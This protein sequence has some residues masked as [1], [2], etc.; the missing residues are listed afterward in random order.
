MR[1]KPAA[2]GRNFS[3]KTE[4]RR[5]CATCR[6]LTRQ[7]ARVA[8]PRR[9]RGRKTFPP[10]ASSRRQFIKHL[11]GGAAIAAAGSAVGRA[12]ESSASYALTQRTPGAPGASHYG[13]LGRTADY[14]DWAV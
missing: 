4:A 1:G 3:K 11:A 5:T 12:A 2:T 6:R 9:D 13:Y 7:T 8:T 10:M 14:R